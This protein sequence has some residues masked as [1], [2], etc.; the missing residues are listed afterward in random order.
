LVGNII[1]ML[2]IGVIAGFLG[3][4]LLPGKQSMSFIMTMLLG[5]AGAVAGFFLFTELLGFGDEDSD[6]FDFSGL[7]GAVIGSMLLLFI[8]DRTIGG[9]DPAPVAGRSDADQAARRE[10]RQERRQDR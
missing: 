2:V 5:I 9:S 3:R 1:S 10:R 6:K 8:Y 7:P 4:A